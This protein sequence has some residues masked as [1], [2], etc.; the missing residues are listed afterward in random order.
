M[1]SGL[2]FD[3]VLAAALIVL[4]IWEGVVAL[5]KH[6]PKRFIVVALSLIAAAAL[7][8]LRAPEWWPR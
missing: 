7:L 2:T 8:Y 6:E 1:P 5:R 4:A 3:L